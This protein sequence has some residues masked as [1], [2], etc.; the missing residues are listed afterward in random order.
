MRPL[1]V[2]FLVALCGGAAHADGT[3]QVYGAGVESC[4]TYVNEAHGSLAK[5]LD[6]QWVLGYV[7]AV[8]MWQASRNQHMAHTDVDAVK[9]W[10]N[11]YC[12]THPLD[13]LNWAANALVVDLAHR[14][15]Q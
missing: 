10:L 12:Q 6:N 8:D 15:D 1:V 14:S 11:N 2:G 5:R 4:G 7:S 9:V 13:Q 3:Y